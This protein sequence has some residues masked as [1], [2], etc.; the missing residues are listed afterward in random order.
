M[1]LLQQTFDPAIAAEFGGK[2]LDFD[3]LGIPVFDPENMWKLLI[4]FV[5]NLLVC[6]VLTH[7]LYYRKSHRKDYYFTFMMFSVTIFL[8]LFL[9]Q[10]LSIEIGFALGLFAIFGMIRYRTETVPIR[11]M[12]YLFIII[13]TSI[14]NG[15]G[16]TASY[17][18]LAVTNVLIIL[19]TWLLEGALKK[20][21]SASKMILYD[22]IELIKPQRYEEML[23]DLHERTGL[24]IVKAEVGHIN[25]LKDTAYLKVTYRPLPGQCE[26]TIDHIVKYK[27]TE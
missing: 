22:K 8:L 10:N 12:T 13:G 11:E 23:A 7:F 2:G 21:H 1:N 9:L 4:L 24:D 15:F 19:V 3:F 14:I 26:S 17:A 16:M 27:G 5:F 18:A 6:W 25:F 20:S